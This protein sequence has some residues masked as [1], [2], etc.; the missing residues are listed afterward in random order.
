MKES[1]VIKKIMQIRNL[2]GFTK[3]DVAQKVHLSDATYGRIESGK[4][5]LSYN[6]LAE[7]ANIFEMSVIDVLA[8]PAKFVEYD[9][10]TAEEKKL[11]K[12]KVILQLE[13]EEDK[14]EQVLKV[15]F[16]ENNLQILNK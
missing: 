2:K 8:Y 12:P 16:G 9:K 1:D 3:R 6:L 5:A 15:V 13:L 14:K 10:L 11:R 4:I 7:I